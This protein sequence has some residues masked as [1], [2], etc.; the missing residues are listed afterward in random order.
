MKNLI[1]AIFLLFSLAIFG[2]DWQLDG[3]KYPNATNQGDT[4]SLATKVPLWDADNLQNYFADLG[5]ILALNPVPP[6]PTL[7][8]V[9]DEGNQVN[10]TDIFL[11]GGS[12]LYVGTPSPSMPAVNQNIRYGNTGLNYLRSNGAGSLSFNM[13]PGD[14]T[15]SGIA[16][17]TSS[18][19]PEDGTQIVI[20]PTE[21]TERAA[22]RFGKLSSTENRR[23]T[24]AP[25][26]NGNDA[27]TLNQ[28]LDSI[29]VY[30]ITEGANTGYATKFR[31]DNPNFYGGI[32][33]LAIDL[34][35]NDLSSGTRGATGANSVAIGYR[36]TASG[37][38][39]TV[40]GGS[41]NL[42]SGYTSIV[43]GGNINNATDT[44]TAI[45]GGLN[46]T[47]TK[48]SAVVVGGQNNASSG[49]QS[50][51]IGGVSNT[52]TGS[53]SVSIGGSSN[54]AT[55]LRSITISGNNSVASG[56][57][58]IVLGGF[59]NYARSYNEVVTGYYSTDYVPTS[60]AL[61]APSDRLFNIG[62]GTSTTSSDA[63]T[64]LKNGETGIGID[65]FEA[66]TTGE[67]L[68]VNGNID[69]TPSGGALLLRSP[70]GTVYELKVDNSGTLT[71]TPQ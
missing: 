22:V 57:E 6:T 48:Q 32:G 36:S 68:Q 5:D 10:S 66:N 54:E 41:G 35:I 50:A 38:R 12:E 11:Y 29:G 59:N 26:L 42:S 37:G 14:G 31:R 20:Y 56:N 8:S 64:I 23:V 28:M 70:D 58:S 2:Q 61:P 7:Q 43:M 60:S 4:V 24:I 65:N 33:N 16:I 71:V 44:Y 15:P 18:S 39:S 9:T 53:Y 30:S 19:T 34:S 52:T 40:V 47:A 17:R 1:T 63:F 21:T 25:A 46:N 69:I 51:I 67:L 45:V 62:N 27:V 3:T 13:S 49:N 55:G